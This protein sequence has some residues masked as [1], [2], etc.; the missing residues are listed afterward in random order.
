MDENKAILNNESANLRYLIECVCPGFSLKDYTRDIFPNFDISLSTLKNALYGISISNKTE[1]IIANSFSLLITDSNENDEITPETLSLSP[2]VFKEKYPM[3]IFRKV[4]KD[5]INYELFA[6]KLYRCYY[7]VSTSPD[8]AFYAFVKIFTVPKGHFAYMIRGIQNKNLL[9][10]LS[11][12]F[13]DIN[14]VEDKF[15][16]LINSFDDKTTESL[17]LYKAES[18]DICF[19][20]NNIRIDF[21]SVE[22]EPCYCI[23]LWNINIPNKVNIR[24]YIGGTGLIMDTNDGRRGKEICAYK[25]GLEAVEKAGGFELKSAEPLNNS[26]TL[27][28][29]HLC[30]KPENGVINIDNGDDSRWYRFI[31]DT[32]EERGGE[33]ADIQYAMELFKKILLTGDS[34]HNP[35]T[36]VLQKLNDD[37]EYIRAFREEL[38][39]KE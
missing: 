24:S 20:Q 6:D 29:N 14:S 31:L 32:D 1:Q 26:S 38:E 15:F 16:Q 23:L 27:L 22:E 30:V 17:N 33:S 21:R 9:T 39:K 18:S 25:I 10:E 34:S 2:E 35:F 11:K 3:N 37:L 28:I 7:M 13:D 8:K 5:T 19:T 4:K 36:E 12:C